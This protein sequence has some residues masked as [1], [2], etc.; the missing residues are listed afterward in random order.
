MTFFF[1][2][3][4]VGV[5]IFT[6]K[7]WGKKVYLHLTTDIFCFIFKVW[8]SRRKE[9][10]RRLLS[11]IPEYLQDG[12]V[13]CGPQHRNST[14]CYPK[15]EV[16]E[17]VCFTTC[18]CNNWIGSRHNQKGWQP[19]LL[20]LAGTSHSSGFIF[21]ACHFQQL[22]LFSPKLICSSEV[23]AWDWLFFFLPDRKNK[24]TGR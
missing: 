10:Y 12:P 5:G 13:V 21:N 11:D 9:G 3:H 24:E 4:K 16:P 7:C 23:P 8:Y 19:R 1:P 2:P 15:T 6:E 22:E 20:Q 14:T 18:R 17:T